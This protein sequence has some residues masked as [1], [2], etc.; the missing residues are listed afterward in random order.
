M[1][2]IDL[3]R[4]SLIGIDRAIIR[5]LRSRINLKVQIVEQ[6]FNCFMD[7]ANK[8]IVNFVRFS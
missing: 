8:R 1:G 3:L 2:G 7:E 4:E 6:V 5:G